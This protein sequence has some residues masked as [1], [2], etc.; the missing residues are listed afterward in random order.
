MP[1]GAR[2][3]PE[4]VFLIGTDFVRSKI[5][6][7]S[8]FGFSGTKRTS[9]K[10]H[11]KRLCGIVYSSR[12]EKLGAYGCDCILYDFEHQIDLLHR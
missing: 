8:S 2:L 6:V 7:G 11:R 9:I 5:I 3:S 12:I 1:N 4:Y 10:D